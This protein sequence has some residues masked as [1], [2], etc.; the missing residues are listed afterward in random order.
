MLF[1]F[2]AGNGA[3][4]RGHAST[5]LQSTVSPV[6][7]CWIDGRH[8]RRPTFKGV[9]HRYSRYSLPRC[10]VSILCFSNQDPIF[11]TSPAA[12]I[13]NTAL[14]TA[15]LALKI[16]LR[17]VL[18]R[19]MANVSSVNSVVAMLMPYTAFQRTSFVNIVVVR[20]SVNSVVI[21]NTWF[22][23][24]KFLIM[25]APL[26]SSAKFQPKFQGTQLEPAPEVFVQ[27]PQ[28]LH[29]IDLVR[30]RSR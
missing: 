2:A 30:F 16:P 15:G 3:S 27:A 17:Y 19:F 29:L 12:S 23:H 26:F 21:G 28:T 22:V 13:L 1:A 4:L 5:N 8:I 20:K 10:T 24:N 11:D 14:V 6:R 18:R 25:N 7:R 9:E